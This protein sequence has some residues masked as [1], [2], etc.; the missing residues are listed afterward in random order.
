MRKSKKENQVDFLKEKSA[1]NYNSDSLSPENSHAISCLLS[2]KRSS[3]CL[4]SCKL[5]TLF[6]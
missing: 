2:P 1:T 6:K 4:S 3:T 5:N